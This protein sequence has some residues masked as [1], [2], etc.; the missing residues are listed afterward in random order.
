MYFV[1]KLRHLIII[2]AIISTIMSAFL[3]GHK[4]IEVF[5]K[6][7]EQSI[8]SSSLTSGYPLPVVMYHNF[9]KSESSCGKYTITPNEFEDDILYLKNKG[10]SF[11]NCDDVINY[12]YSNISLPEKSIMI[13]IDDGYYNNYL[14]IF[15][16]IKKHNVKVV[17][18]PIGIESDRYSKSMDLNPAYANMCWDNIKE[19]KESGLVQIQNHSYNLH[20][21]SKDQTGCSQMKNEDDYAYSERI[22]SDLKKANEVIFQNTGYNPVCMTFPFGVTSKKVNELV[23]SMGFKMSLSCSEGVSY[24]DHNPECLYMIKRYNRPH[25]ISRDVFFKGMIN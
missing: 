15:P 4:A 7:F 18:S 14:Y 17:I 20:H 1:I 19:M 6:A 9:L 23:K 16:I 2:A 5:C 25:N 3:W 24:I 21:A 11:V 8:P 10:Y 12:V 13:T 22:F